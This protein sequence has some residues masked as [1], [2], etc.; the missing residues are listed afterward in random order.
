[1]GIPCLLYLFTKT[2]GAMKGAV[3]TFVWLLVAPH[4][5]VFMMTIISSEI[6]KG[7]HGQILG[8]SIAGTALLIVLAIFIA[9]V[10]LI[11]TM[12][13]SITGVSS[14]GSI[15]STLLAHK[16]SGFVSRMLTSKNRRKILGGLGRLWGKN[17]A[18]KGDKT[19]LQGKTKLNQKT[20]LQ[21]REEGKNPK[22]ANPSQK[23]VA[24]KDSTSLRKKS[25]AKNLDERNRTDSRQASES[26]RVKQGRTDAQSSTTTQIKNKHASGVNKTSRHKSSTT[27]PS[28]NPELSRKSK[29]KKV[30]IKNKRR[31]KR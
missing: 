21:R 13:I 5:L 6:N 4:V 12:L 19:Q 10:P 28:K 20:S 25:A 22:N 29:N 17:E 11:T 27:S 23:Q 31:N 30:R 9:F 14:A 15:I 7:Y 24:G 1:M 2:Q 8:G 18:G 26:S 3:T 16:V